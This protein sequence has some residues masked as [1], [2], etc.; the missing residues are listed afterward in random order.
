MSGVSG[1]LGRVPKAVLYVRDYN[2]SFLQLMLTGELEAVLS[3]L[4]K[5]TNSALDKAE[6]GL[7]EGAGLAR[8]AATAAIQVGAA[9]SGFTSLKVQYNPS[10][11]YLD[12]I[13]GTQEI[14]SGMLGGLINNQITQINTGVITTLGVQLI[15]DDMNQMDAFGIDS[16][17]LSTG[18]AAALIGE[19]IRGRNYSVRKPVEGLIACLLSPITRRVIFCWSDIVFK[20]ELNQVNANYT[21]FNKRGEPIRATVDLVIQQQPEKDK[22]EFKGYWNNAFD[23]AF[24]ESTTGALSMGEKLTNNA[25]M[26][27]N[28]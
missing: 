6:M 19:K 7:L 3:E 4:M 23:R 24:K 15:F 8:E 26:N 2:M 28:V 13:Q 20:G 21:M 16:G 27:I 18:G 12:N 14:K 5:T 9:I 1:L 25:F 22:D 10:S 17:M 11:I